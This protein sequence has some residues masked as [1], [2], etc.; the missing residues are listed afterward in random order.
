MGPSK[1]GG[2]PSQHFVMRIMDVRNDR[3]T[4][5]GEGIDGPTDRAIGKP[6]GEGTMTDVTNRWFFEA[7]AGFRPRD[8][9]PM[10]SPLR[11]RGANGRG[12]AGQMLWCY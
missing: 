7:P 3:R 5:P 10:Y 9:N 6:G 4:D 8:D 1:A 11:E 2:K 12:F